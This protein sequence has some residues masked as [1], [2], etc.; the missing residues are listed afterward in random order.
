MHAPRGYPD[1]LRATTAAHTTAVTQPAA[2]SGQNLESW[3]DASR[4]ARRPRDDGENRV[5]ASSIHSL[6]DARRGKRGQWGIPLIGRWTTQADRRAS[7]NP[8]VTAVWKHGR[9]MKAPVSPEALLEAFVETADDAMF[10][11]RA[12]RNITSWNPAAERFFGY[13]AAEVLGMPSTACSPITSATTSERCS[14]P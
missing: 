9:P 7:Q 8:Q 11:S 12:G 5:L 10:R 4:K 3:S 6:E 13:P 1:P 14:R 2:A